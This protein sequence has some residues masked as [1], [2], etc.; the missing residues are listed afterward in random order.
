MYAVWRLVPLASHWVMQLHAPHKTTS[1]LCR[2]VRPRLRS[3]TVELLQI[4]TQYSSVELLQINTQY[5][6]CTFYKGWLSVVIYF[7]SKYHLAGPY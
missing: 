2:A 7:P 6:F 3:L 4:N 1:G 5:M